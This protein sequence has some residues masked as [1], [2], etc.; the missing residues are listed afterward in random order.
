MTRRQRQTGGA[1]LE[2]AIALPFA[3][4]VFLGIGDFSIYFWRQVQMEEVARIALAT[5]V[6]SRDGY[7]NADSDALHRFEQ[8]LQNAVRA[9]TGDGTVRIHLSHHYACPLPNG[10]EKSL[11]ASPQLCAGERVYLRMAGDRAVSP[12]FGPL[13]L[14]GYPSTAFT[15]HFVRLR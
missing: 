13:R 5:V 15:R 14:L 12:L 8:V 2:F 10:T 7:A 9:E 11:T 3:L 1:I 6:P 4:S